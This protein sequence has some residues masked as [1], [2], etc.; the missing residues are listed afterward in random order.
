M[1]LVPRSQT[2]LDARISLQIYFGYAARTSPGIGGASSFTHRRQPSIGI[3]IGNIT[4]SVPWRG[5][6]F[7]YMCYFSLALGLA[8]MSR[9]LATTW[10]PNTEC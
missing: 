5:E 4:S 9:F 10:T 1:K 6:A 8:A 3:Y 7:Y 2:F